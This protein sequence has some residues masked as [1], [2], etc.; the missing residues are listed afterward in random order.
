MKKVFVLCLTSLF[1][2]MEGVYAY[3]SGTHLLERDGNEVKWGQSKNHRN[4]C[5]PSYNYFC[6]ENDEDDDQ[7]GHTLAGCGAIA[8][9]QIMAQ[10]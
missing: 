6:P 3:E 4:S 1:L 5:S 7:C 10:W 2:G 9:A 8:M